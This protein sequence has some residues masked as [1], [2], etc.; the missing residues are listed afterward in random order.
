VSLG[1]L[2]GGP[3]SSFATGV[4]DDGNTVVGVGNSTY[5][6]DSNGD[7]FIWTSQR[8]MRLLK[9]AVMADY[10]APQ[11][12]GWHLTTA[13]GI[14]GDGRSIVGEGINPQGHL[15]AYIVRLGG[16]P[17][18]ADFN[19]DGVVNVR[20]FLAYLAAYAAGCP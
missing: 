5:S 12:E 19:H 3:T 18:P 10:S 17:C 6:V 15:E 7:A 14:S 2:P 8:G 11:L 16:G 13:W 4:S 1:D 9:D 20:D